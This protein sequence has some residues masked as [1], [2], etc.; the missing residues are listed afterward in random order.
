MKNKKSV[1]YVIV[2]VMFSI[3]SVFQL[4]A[5][6]EKDADNAVKDVVDEYQEVKLTPYNFF[7]YYISNTD[8]TFI[9]SYKYMYAYIYEYKV[10]YSIKC[11]YSKAIS[12]NVTV[13]FKVD[14]DVYYDSD[15]VL[16]TRNIYKTIYLTDAGI[17]DVS[18]N[19]KDYVV[20][21]GDASGGGIELTKYT[22]ESVTGTIKI[23]KN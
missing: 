16:Q 22:I 14:V 19:Y 11:K 17:G 12:N 4:A 18:Y 6:G 9:R 7:D 21:S 8:S 10:D 1:I 2:V 23:P 13:K 15:D 5:C 3:L 20:S